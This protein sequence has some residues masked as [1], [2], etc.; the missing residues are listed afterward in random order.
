MSPILREILSRCRDLQRK[1]LEREILAVLETICQDKPRFFPVL[2]LILYERDILPEES[3][4][5][6]VDDV[7]MGRRCYPRDEVCDSKRGNLIRESQPLIE[8]FC[9]S[10]DGDETDH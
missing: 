2:A 7:R 4:F 8:W 9:S 3:I 1:D 6:W 10:D 5:L